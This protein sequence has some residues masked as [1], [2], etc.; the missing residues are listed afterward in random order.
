MTA[1]TPALTDAERDAVR[2]AGELYCLIRDKVCGHGPSREADLA[3]LTAD[4]HRIQRLVMAQAA[5]RLY[6]GEFRLMGEV[7]GGGR[8]AGER[9]AAAPA[10]PD[11]PG[12]QWIGQSFATC[13][14]CGKPAWEHGGEMRLRE[15]A[16]LVIGG[17]GDWELRPWKPGEAEAIKRKWA[18]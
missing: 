4:V 2:M 13:D 9:V 8:A 16:K 1:G 5:A 10:T 3:E 6:P 7:I 18:R 12:F 11:C 17:T 14:G 15:G